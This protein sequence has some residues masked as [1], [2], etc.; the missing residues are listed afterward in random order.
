MLEIILLPYSVA[1][2]GNFIPPIRSV[3]NI[4]VISYSKSMIIAH[5]TSLAIGEN[6]Y[7]AMQVT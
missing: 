1:K 6:E 7:L 4:D 3:D 5:F 2:W